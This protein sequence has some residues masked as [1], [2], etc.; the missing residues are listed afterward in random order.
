MI[1]GCWS[2][3]DPAPDDKRRE[4]YKKPSCRYNSPLADTAALLRRWH[5]DSVQDRW[6]C[7]QRAPP[8][9]SHE[10]VRCSGSWP[11]LCRWRCTN[12][13]YAGRPWPR[14]LWAD[15]QQLFGRFLNAA[16]RFG[17][18]VSLWKTEVMLQPVN[19]L[20]PSP[21]VI[22]AGETALPAVEKFCYLGSMLSSDANIDNISS[23]LAKASHSFG[24]LSRRLWD[25]H[26]LDPTWY[27][28]GSLQGSHPDCTSLWVR[29]MGRI[30]S[31]CAETRT[32]PHVLPPTL[33]TRQMAR[34]EVKHRGLADR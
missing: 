34:E 23:R 11:S 24:R 33:G 31:T 1:C 28:S 10:D 22:M 4:K 5:S 32:I 15:A 27:Q 16:T 25:D 30:S 9:I 13:T 26:R 14:G 18:T 2:L 19:C 6:Q 21:P 3:R 29:N 17:L 7:L 8:T 12:G 20:T